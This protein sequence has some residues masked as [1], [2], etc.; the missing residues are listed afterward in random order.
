MVYGLCAKGRRVG[1]TS[2]FNRGRL[3]NWP[4]AAFV[5]LFGQITQE[6]IR[7]SGQPRVFE[8]SSSLLVRKRVER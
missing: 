3:A 2:G 4:D 1:S 8:G 5:V 7:V 6:Y